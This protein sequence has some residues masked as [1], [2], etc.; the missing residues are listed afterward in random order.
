MTRRIAITFAAIAG[1]AAGLGHAGQ[2]SLIADRPEG[3]AGG[4]GL[5]LNGGEIM[6]AALGGCFWNDLH[7]VAH[8]EGAPVR[9]EN[10]EAEI[11]LAGNPPRIARA[12]LR[13]TLSGADE[14]TLVRVFDAAC[15]D[16]TIANSVTAAF[17][18]HFER[19]AARS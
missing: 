11:E 3:V 4:R 12:F 8:A 19:K 13:A 18:V 6:A 9:V 10:V 17:P 16:S 5:G 7:H 15:E 2:H 1:T 14:A